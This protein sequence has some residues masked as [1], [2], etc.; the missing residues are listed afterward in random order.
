MRCIRARVS[1]P[2]R[3]RSRAPRPPRRRIARSRRCRLPEPTRLRARS[4]WIWMAPQCPRCT[5]APGAVAPTIPASS[6]GYLVFLLDA[7]TGSDALLYAE[8]QS[9]PAAV[10]VPAERVSVPWTL[11]S[12]SPDGYSGTI[13]ATVLPCDGYPNP[14]N[15]DHD[16]AAVSV[17]VER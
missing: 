12:R 3:S 15:V 5:A 6:H 17:V 7:Q 11:V 14:V 9:G 2:S 13:S 4:A 1:L 10:T 8:R 16:R